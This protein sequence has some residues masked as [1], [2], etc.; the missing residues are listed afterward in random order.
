M[1]AVSL[2]FMGCSYPI[3][4]GESVTDRH[5]NRAA[6]ARRVPTMSTVQRPCVS[7]PMASR[8]DNYSGL[9]RHFSWAE[10]VVYTCQ[11]CGRAQDGL[12]A[13]EAILTCCSF[14]VGQIFFLIF[15][16]RSRIYLHLHSLPWSFL[17]FSVSLSFSA[18]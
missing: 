10:L 7:P 2:L 17:F 9:K 6:E 12:F 13:F 3:A 8:T 11:H 4:T 5:L 15:N 14:S 18:R 1:R 16:P